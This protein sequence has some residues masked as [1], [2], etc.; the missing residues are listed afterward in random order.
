MDNL[1]SGY[2]CA[3]MSC[4]ET[5]VTNCRPAISNL[6]LWAHADDGQLRMCPY[7]QTN[8]IEYRDYIHRHTMC[9]NDRGEV[10]REWD[11]YESKGS[12]GYGC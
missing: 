1:Q 2:N 9:V 5:A 3:I 7:V 4:D 12:V 11:E 10:E 6:T 8:S